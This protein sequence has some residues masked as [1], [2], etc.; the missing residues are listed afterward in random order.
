M[1]KEINGR[2]K[3]RFFTALA[4]VLGFALFG[5]YAVHADTPDDDAAPKTERIITH[6][7]QHYIYDYTATGDHVSVEGSEVTYADWN[8]TPVLFPGDTVTI[9]PGPPNPGVAERAG[10]AVTGY[11][12][13]VFNTAGTE[14]NPVEGV[15][16]I[17]VTKT[18][19]YGGD[20]LVVGNHENEFI[21]EFK[22]GGTEPVLL[23]INGGG[24]HYSESFYRPDLEGNITLAYYA[25]YLNFKYYPNYCRVVYEYADINTGGVGTFDKD[26]VDQ[27]VKYYSDEQDVDAIWDT[28]AVH[29]TVEG[30]SSENLVNYSAQHPYIEGL[31][32]SKFII[33]T[34]ENVVAYKLSNKSAYDAETDSYNIV[35]WWTVTNDRTGGDNTRKGSYTDDY[36]KVR[37][38]YLPCRTVTLD[39]CG[40]TINGYASRIY[41]A[42]NT[43]KTKLVTMESNGLLT[44]VREGYYF[45][46]W[47]EDEAY[48]TPV[49]DFWTSVSKYSNSDSD[50][51][52]CSCH[53]Y[54][55]WLKGWVQEGDFKYYY[56]EN[57][58][59]TGWQTIEGN[60]YYFDTD[61]DEYGAMITGWWEIGDKLYYFDDDGVVVTG[62]KTIVGATY[63]FDED[64]VMQ[65]GF[66]TVDGKTY[67]FN[68]DGEMQTDW[69]TVEGLR[70]YFNENGEMQTGLQTIGGKKYGFGTDGA[71]LTGIQTIDGKTYGFGF[72][73][74]ML[75][76]LKTVSGKK[77]YF[78]KDGVMQTGLQTINGKTY[79]FGT[80][81]AML[82][83]AQ[84]IDQKGYYFDKD[85]VMQTGW[86]PAGE[87]KYYCGTDGVMRK[88]LQTID[89][90]KY[91][92]DRNGEMQTGLQT[93][94]G[95][96]YCFDADGEMQTGLRT[97]GGITFGFGPDGAL[98]SGI[99]TINGKK[100]YF[101]PGGVMVSGKMNISGKWYYFGAGGAMQTGVVQILGKWYCF[102]DDG[103]MIIG[104]GKCKNKYYFGS[105]NQ[106]TLGEL[107][108][109]WFKD[110]KKWYFFSK[111]SKTLG[112]MKTGWVKDGKKWYF[113]SKDSKA[114]GKMMT[115]WVQDGKTWYFLKADGSM[116]ANEYCKGYW[117]DK[118]GKWTYKRKASWK[119]D[120]AG[121]WY[122]DGKWYA[123][124]CTLTIDGKKYSFDAKGYMK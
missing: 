101:G 57:G 59:V 121:W 14:D 4:V 75:T 32:I 11:A 13:L 72:D 45:G 92:F 23:C 103:T 108:T 119:K 71:M 80:D 15:A 97:V 27:N 116:A 118:S 34:S 112:Q 39:A 107:K 2:I 42:S 82:T 87:K 16:P 37:F 111:D 114:L 117:L 100:Y 77:R 54:A 17:E 48:T 89:G 102:A 62:M 79:G 95:K 74:V 26:F 58:P 70:Y 22:I 85:G 53:L 122:G 73:G 94:D 28:D 30:Y 3:R 88:G 86:Q 68:T 52:K 21:Q 6:T 104:W 38:E 78:D 98:L 29:N 36:V 46:G 43:D 65:T 35:P 40:G 55:R 96:T 12:G 1:V 83:G 64:G 33:D 84:T 99:Q 20:G 24:G 9:I 63:Y 49:M 50:R 19:V 60:K 25:S 18:K 113:M 41:E 10:Q 91:Y 90:K 124:S 31:H 123:K 120:K 76:G 44:P 67:Y 51:A 47:Y 81:G 61:E 115:G 66:Q 69:Q 106:L 7:P 5:G 109:G 56:D 105:K 93:V 110:G 8:Q